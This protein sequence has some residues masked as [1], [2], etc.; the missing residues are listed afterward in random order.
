MKRQAIIA[1]LMGSALAIAMPFAASA[2]AQ[3]ASRVG[4][5][6]ASYG[7]RITLDNGM[8]VYFHQGTIIKP[9][10]MSLY[11]GMRVRVSGMRQ[12]HVRLDA[13]EVHLINARG[14][15]VTK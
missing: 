15:A 9:T 13:H 8:T 12:S 1:T 11:P 10:G 4:L 6:T 7:D 3:Y 5:V 14:Q 2:Q